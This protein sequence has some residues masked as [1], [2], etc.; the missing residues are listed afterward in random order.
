MYYLFKYIILGDTG[1]GKSCIFSQFTEKCF[2]PTHDSENG[3]QFGVRKITIYGKQI[4]LQIWDTDDQESFRPITRSYYQGAAGVLLV[5]D[6]TRRDTFNHLTSYLKNARNNSNS[7]VVI[8]LIGNKSDLKSSREVKR[9][10]GESF[11]RENGLV[12]METSAKT[13]A[14]VEKAFIDTAKEIYRK[15]QVEVCKNFY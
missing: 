15:M 9:K 8:M 3:L 2:T 12:F 5:Y 4:K 14:N 7:N 6:I 10:E 13:V 1:V 11:A